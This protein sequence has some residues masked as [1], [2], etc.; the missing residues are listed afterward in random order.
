MGEVGTGEVKRETEQMLRIATFQGGGNLC[1]GCSGSLRSYAGAAPLPGNARKRSHAGG[2]K[3]SSGL[4]SWGEYLFQSISTLVHIAVIS[5]PWGYIGRV[6]IAGEAAGEWEGENLWSTAP[7]AAAAQ[8]GARVRQALLD[9]ISTGF[10]DP[11][12]LWPQ[13]RSLHW[14]FPGNCLGLRPLH[15][16]AQLRDSVTDS[17][18]STVRGPPACRHGNG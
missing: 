5:L 18:L 11:S 14:R 3:G 9:S 13:R 10:S 6:A 1:G 7:S 4:G 15:R 16:E 17:P 8:E 2:G 12:P